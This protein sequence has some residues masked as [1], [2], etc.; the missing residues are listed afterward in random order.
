[1]KR[2]KD[3]VVKRMIRVDN[4]E[5]RVREADGDAPSRT[6]TGYAIL[7]NTPSVPLWSDEDSEAR[8]VIAPEAITKELLDGCDIKF[9][10]FHDRQIILGRSN[11]GSGTLEYFVDEKGV[12]F[13]LELPRSANGDEA[14]ELVRRGDI[15]GCSFAFTTH[16]WDSDFVVRSTKNVNGTVMITYTVRAVTG[17]YDFTL[18]ADPAYPDTSVEAREFADG[19]REDEK[20]KKDEPKPDNDKMREQVREMRRAAARKLV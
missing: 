9:T 2:N 10:M 17:V 5:L 11:K 13:N 15:S 20:P 6:I 19:L 4:A 7:F 8:E 16:Y 12:G 14:L 18:A 1:M 3:T